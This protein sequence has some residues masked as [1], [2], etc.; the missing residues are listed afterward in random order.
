MGK[1]GWFHIN[2]VPQA[3]GPDQALQFASGSTG[4]FSGSSKL[5]F[6]YYN[7]IMHLTGN[8][9]IS[10]T[11]KANHFNIHTTT[12]TEMDISGS[13]NFGNDTGDKHNFTGSVAVSGAFRQH[14]IK[15]TSSPYTVATYDTIIGISSSAYISVTLPNAAVAGHGRVLIIKDEWH[16]T[17]TSANPIAVSASSGQKIDHNPTYSLSGDSP[18]LSIYSDGVSKWFI[19]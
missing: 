7:N 4:Q 1:F 16:A 18:A 8:L 19:Y 6:D 9:E 11:L 14:Y 12:K 10:G 3:Q 5:T 2:N 15:V 13:T 17:R